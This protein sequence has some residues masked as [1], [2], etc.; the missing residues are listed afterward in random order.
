MLD[1]HLKLF[2]KSVKAPSLRTNILNW[3][4]KADAIVSKFLILFNI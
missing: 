2:E 3:E 4:R 1:D